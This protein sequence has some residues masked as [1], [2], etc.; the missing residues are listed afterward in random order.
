MLIGEV[1]R[2]SG[3]SARML[4]HYDAIG[5]VAPSERSTSGYRRYS[6]ADLQRLFHV[7]SLRSLGLSLPEVR[8]A[9]DDPG[10]APSELV[11]ELV[12][13]TRERISAAEE[14]LGRLDRVR[15][16]G[17][18]RWGEVLRT[19]ALVRGLQSDD[20]SRRQLSALS[21]SEDDALRLVGPLAEA[22]LAEPDPVVAGALRWAVRQSGDEALDVLAPALDSPDGQRRERAVTTIAQLSTERSTAVLTGVLGHADDAIRHRA[23]LALGSRGEPVA[24]AV[25]VEMVLTG[26]QDVEAAEVLGALARHH[27]LTDPVGAVLAHAVQRGGGGPGPRTRITQ[28]LAELP[29]ALARPTLEVLG[30]DDDPEVARTAAYVLQRFATTAAAGHAGC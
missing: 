18:D 22:L 6:E 8:R 7:E 26:H 24:V 12:A 28:A 3:V 9:L 17:P 30:R 2:H 11:E 4:R 20:P 15:A 25:L 5:L 29:A 10:F 16:G 1:S 19:V 27:D 14:L 13:R 23:A 21:T